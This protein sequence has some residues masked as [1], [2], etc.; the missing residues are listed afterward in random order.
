MEK[1]L[2]GL[3]RQQDMLHDNPREL[4]HLIKQ[5]RTIEKEFSRV[6]Y[7]L[8]EASK[9]RTNFIFFCLFVLHRKSV[10]LMIGICKE[11]AYVKF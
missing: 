5:Q 3:L 11:Y 10:I 2:Q 6:L 8:A 7:Q 1:A 4:D 9:V